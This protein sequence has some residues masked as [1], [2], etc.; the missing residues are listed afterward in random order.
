N[1][2]QVI[3]EQV[4]NFQQHWPA[5]GAPRTNRNHCAAWPYGYTIV[6]DGEQENGIAADT[7]YY[8]WPGYFW[9]FDGG[10]TVIQ[11]FMTGSGLPMKYAR[12]DGSVTSVYQMHTHITDETQ[13]SK[14]CDTTGGNPGCSTTTDTIRHILYFLGNAL[15]DG[16]GWYGA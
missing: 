10:T 16:I 8:Y 13:D 1:V 7:N 2:S 3:R 6:A 14:D 15:D 5:A 4:A 12:T 11:G 9:S